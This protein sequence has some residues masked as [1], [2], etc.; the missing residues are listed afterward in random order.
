M[1]AIVEV[2]LTGVIGVQAAAVRLP[3]ERAS[4]VSATTATIRTGM[5]RVRATRLHSVRVT[6]PAS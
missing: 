2:T 4:G 6:V 3:L 1:V 5:A